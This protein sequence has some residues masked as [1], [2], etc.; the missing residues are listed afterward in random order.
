MRG[1][2]RGSYGSAQRGEGIPRGYQR[3]S[4]SNDRSRSPTPAARETPSSSS[5]EGEG[6][7]MEFRPRSRNGSRR[8]GSETQV[9][10]EES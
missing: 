1:K 3:Y 6:S 8:H 2:S 10:E 4:S 9:R 7:E 5:A